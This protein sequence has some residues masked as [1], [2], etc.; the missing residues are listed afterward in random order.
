MQESRPSRKTHHKNVAESIINYLRKE[1]A[2][3]SSNGFETTTKQLAKAIGASQVSITIN[4]RK[5]LEHHILVLKRGNFVPG[6]SQPKS[7]ALA[8]GYEDG[9]SWKTALKRKGMNDNVGT[10]SDETEKPRNHRVKVRDDVELAKT[11][12][13]CLAKLN[14]TKIDNNNLR[15]QLLEALKQKETLEAKNKELQSEVEEL[16]ASE[17]QAGVDL[18]KAHQEINQLIS[19]NLAEEKK[20]IRLNRQ[21]ANFNR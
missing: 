1:C 9:N 19:R 8:E 20:E 2:V 10:A 5:F 21:I 18:L 6:S 15:E 7:L 16:K 13:E 17:H 3:S 12:T 14:Q 4:L 11:L